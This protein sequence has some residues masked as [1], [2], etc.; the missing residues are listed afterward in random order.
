MKKIFTPKH[1]HRADKKEEKVV[2]PSEK[3]LDFLRQF[4]RVHH[5]EKALPDMING[6][7]IN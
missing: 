2:A 6:L 3:T 7:C 4:A 5:V 1:Y